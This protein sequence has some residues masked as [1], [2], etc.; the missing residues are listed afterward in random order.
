MSSMWIA[1]NCCTRM[2]TKRKVSP[3]GTLRAV[4]GAPIIRCWLLLPE[5]EADLKAANVKYTMHMYPQCNH[6]FHNDSTSRY[7]EKNAKLAWDR[8]VE[9]FKQHLA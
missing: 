1:R 9:F 6:G 4:R 2:A 8:T 3:R 5:Y 7:D